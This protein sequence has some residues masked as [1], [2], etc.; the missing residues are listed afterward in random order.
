MSRTVSERYLLIIGVFMGLKDFIN[1]LGD[2][3]CLECGEVIKDGE[4]YYVNYPSDYYCLV[5]GAE[6][7]R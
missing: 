1:S 2:K 4:R 5:C 6:R 3:T 7:D